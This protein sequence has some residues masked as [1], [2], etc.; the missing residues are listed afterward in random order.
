MRRVGFAV[1]AL[2]LLVGATVPASGSSVT[3]A[4]GTYTSIALTDSAVTV[5]GRGKFSD[6]EVTV[7]QTKNLLN[8][9]VSVT[10]KGGTPT[11]RDPALF[12]QNFLQIMQCWGDDDGTNPDNPGPPPTQCAFGARNGTKE[13]ANA[14]LPPGTYGADRVISRE[15]W[16]NYDPEAGVTAKDVGDEWLPFKAVKGDTVG[17]GVDYNFNPSAEGGVYWQNPYFNII[18]TNEIAGALTLNDGSGSDLFEVQTGVENSGLGCGQAVEP[19]AGGGTKVPKCWLVVVPR[20]SAED[21]NAGTPYVQDADNWGVMT[22]PLSPSVWK[23]RIAIPLEFNAVDS[24]CSLAEDATRLVGTELAQAAISSWQPTLCTTPG[25]RPYAYGNVADSSARQ[26]ILNGGANAPGMA[27][28]NKPVDHDLLDPESP[29]VYAPLT[30]SG[31]T[32]GFNVERRPSLDADADAQKLTAVRVAHINLTPRLIA[33]LLT[34]SYKRQT[35][36]IVQA[37]YEWAKANPDNMSEDPDFIK[38]N[39]EFKEQAVINRRN[40]SGLVVPSGISDSANVL[41]NYVLADPEARAWLSGEADPY[42]MVVNPVYAIEAAKNSTGV[43]FGDPAPSDYPKSDPYCF[44]EK[45]LG[46]NQIIPPPLC[47]TDY[48]PYGQSLHDT[49]HSARAADDGAK[50]NEN[51]N[52]ASSAAVWQRLGPQA[53]AKAMFS[54]TDTASANIFGLQ[55]A[56]LSRAGDDDEDRRF[57]SPTRTSLDAAVA[58][59]S[60]K[61]EPA[62]LEP[63]PSADVPGGYPLTLLSYAVTKPLDLSEQQRK[64]YAAFVQ[65][66]ASDGQ[67]PG[68][69]YG[70]LPIGYAPLPD[71][72]KTQA[73]A[74]AK[75]IV[76]LKA[77]GDGAVI[78]SSG[79]R[80][81]GD[82]LALPALGGSPRAHPVKDAATLATPLAIAHAAPPKPSALKRFLTPAITVA[83]TRF[84]IPA[85]AFIA[86]VASLFALEITKRPRRK[87]AS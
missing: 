44:Q 52:P 74:A 55:A 2:A 84:A 19:V 57:I 80:S 24:S 79:G 11:K 40:F 4:S 9:A 42:G 21:E 70:K 14:P 60:A 7:N 33:K 47:G 43:A 35:L 65:Y 37:P 8:Q 68:L 87:V 36:I 17:V 5:G 31:L 58:G 26:Q 50:L 6:L 39:P 51:K 28:V 69:E 53:I 15:G 63:D 29:A 20:G 71:F 73:R 3:G 48:M 56:S 67:V 1:I 75:T 46:N 66:A 82:S 64:D 49:A 30:V 18:T 61:S 13:H 83:A 32:I 81:D 12:S 54:L 10:W 59:M 34:Q 23:Q 22:S 78:D 85:L 62:V 38:F 76:E 16:D 41:W 77:A 72:L 45:P 86:L 25:L 27:V